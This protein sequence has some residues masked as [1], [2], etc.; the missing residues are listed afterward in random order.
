MPA[1]ASA[2]ERTSRHPWAM[3]AAQ[4]GEARTEHEGYLVV[5]LALQRNAKQKGTSIGKISFEG[6]QNRNHRSA[7]CKSTWGST[8]KGRERT[9]R[10]T[11]REPA[12]P[13]KPNTT[14]TPSRTLKH[15]PPRHAANS[16]VRN[17][18]SVR[19]HQDEP[20][21]D[22]C[23]RNSF[24]HE[25]IEL[26]NNGANTTQKEPQ[27]SLGQSAR[28]ATLRACSSVKSGCAGTPVQKRFL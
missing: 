8:E 21:E 26:C 9:V 25:S 19:T 7:Q 2:S 14:H 16:M 11:S 12:N 18:A 27:H 10:C 24:S 1:K 20:C 17:P 15:C 22:R 13:Q 23:A 4:H 5:R 6:S 3:L 28:L